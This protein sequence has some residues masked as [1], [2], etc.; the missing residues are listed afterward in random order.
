MYDYQF[1]YAWHNTERQWNV[2]F[3]SQSQ[4]MLN[5]IIMCSLYDDKNGNSLVIPQN[6]KGT[7]ASWNRL[8]VDKGLGNQG[9]GISTMKLFIGKM[10]RLLCLGI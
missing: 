10:L 6:V 9:H 1:T 3:S 4:F 5:M 7:W 2:N 8:Y